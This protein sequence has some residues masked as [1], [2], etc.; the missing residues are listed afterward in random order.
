MPPPGLNRAWA[1]LLT[2]SSYL[3]GVLTLA[4]TLLKHNTSYPIVVLVTPSLPA[5]SLRAL[6]LESAHNPL[7]R[8]HP[9]SP[10]LPPSHHKTTLIAARFEDTWTKLR[11]FELTSYDAVIFLD[12]DIA[13]FRNMDA[14][15]DTPLPSPSWLAATHICACN[16][17]HDAWAPPDWTA[18]SCAYTPLRHPSALSAPTPVPHSSDRQAKP[19]H[20]MLNGGMF[21][22]H[23]SAALWDSLLAAFTASPHLSAYQFPDQ[24]FLAAFFRDRWRP[25]PWRYNALK[26]MR[27]WHETIWRDGEVCALHYIVDKPWAR[28]IARDGVAGHLGRDGVTHGWWWEI[29]E[30]WRQERRGGEEL[31]AIVAEV[32]APPL[33]EEGEERQRR[34]NRERGLPVPVPD[35]PG[36]VRDGVGRE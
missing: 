14:A 10:L 25:L 32:V 16:L 15:F 21:L 4:Y 22:F 36:M 27:Y 9:I 18:S 19:T 11:V 29:W 13:I 31:L 1:T 6:E 12:A 34:E 26:T 20:A 28:R 33:D 35:H 17:D 2:R 7:I 5:S 8:V 3:P 24:D 30:G 23:P